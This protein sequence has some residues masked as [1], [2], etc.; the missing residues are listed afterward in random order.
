MALLPIL[1]VCCSSGTID[2]SQKASFSIDGN[3]MNGIEIPA[4][5]Y[6]QSFSV[7]SDSDWEIVRR[8][9]QRWIDISPAKGNGNSSV[10]VFAEKNTSGQR[11]RAFF[12]VTVNGVK[13]YVIEIVQTTEVVEEQKPD[14][15]GEGETPNPSDPPDRKSVV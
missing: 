3:L 15:G 8:S 5:K 14:Q 6:E 4:N 7:T 10:T 2:E 13:S 1:L 11:R 12:D 9:G